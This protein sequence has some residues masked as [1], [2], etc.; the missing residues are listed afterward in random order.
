MSNFVLTINAVGPVFVIVFL[1]YVLRILKMADDRFADTASRIIYTIALPALI[2]SS[3]AK[4]DFRTAFD[5]REILFAI[6]GSILIFSIAWITGYTTLHEG[7]DR[8]S[9]IQGCFRSNFA[10]VGFAL[11]ESIFGGTALSKAALVLAFIQPVY[12]ILAVISLTVPLKK[13][14]RN[15]THTIVDVLRN[16]L[17]ISVLAA[18]PFSLFSLRLPRFISGSLDNLSALTLPLALLAIG[19]GMNM[20]TLKGT[21]K[22]AI[23]ASILR[24]II[25]PLLITSI[26]VAMGFRGVELGIIFILFATPTAVAS[27]AMAQAMGCNGKLAGSIVIMS[28]MFSAFTITLGLYI[29][30][31]LGFFQ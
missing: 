26:A 3:I 18:I 22:P 9:F 23:T 15:L 17:M 29:I 6:A 10:I 19:A 16:P 24:T 13:K 7:A 2:F 5:M 1:G 27:F 21:I 11:I 12:T 20:D 8:G 25:F 14:D 4:T 31:S 28:T 30:R